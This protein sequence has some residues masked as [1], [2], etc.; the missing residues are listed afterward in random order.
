MTQKFFK[1]EL[2]DRT[3]AF[4]F[5]IANTPIFISTSYPPLNDPRKKT[6]KSHRLNPIIF[7]GF[8]T[9]YNIINSHNFKWVRKMWE[10]HFYLQHIQSYGKNIT[11]DPPPFCGCSKNQL[12]SSLDTVCKGYIFIWWHWWCHRIISMEN[13]PRS[14]LNTEL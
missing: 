8:M 1:T 12:C 4:S 14:Q 6:I 11:N 7:V 9:I 3:R 2:I 5:I 10:I 13:I